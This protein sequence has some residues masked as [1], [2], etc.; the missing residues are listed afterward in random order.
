LIRV[1]LIAPSP[2]LRLGLRSLLSS[3]PEIRIVAERG[4]W[5]ET[6]EF[7]GDVDVV[8]TTS[9]SPDRLALLDGDLGASVPVLYIGDEP[10]ALQGGGRIP[11]AFGALPQE[12]SAAELCAAVQALAQGLVVGTPQL[13]FNSEERSAVGSP[14]TE[15]E[16]E[17]LRWLAQ[18][19]ANKQIAV[20]LGISEHTVKF[21]VSSI[22]SKL[23]ATNRT[24]AVREGLRNGWI[25]L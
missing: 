2:A 24:Q 1:L 9:T 23:N 12:T 4:R 3:E 6:Q 18:G 5:V 20:E 13:L 8:I 14:L 22:Y 10:V 11:A 17:V 21:H 7:E 25:P 15:R 19:L 16:A